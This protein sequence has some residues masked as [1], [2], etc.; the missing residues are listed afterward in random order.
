MIF[1]KVF[2]TAVTV[3]SFFSTVRAELTPDDT[4]CIRWRDSLVVAGVRSLAI[5]DFY[6]ARRYFTAAFQCGMHRDSM[7]YFAAEMY[8]RR[9]ALDTALVFNRALEKSTTF[10]RTLRDEQRSRIYRLL[11]RTD[12]ADS[13]AALV[14]TPLRHDI[15]LN[16]SG[17]RRDMV[18]GPITFLPQQITIT[19]GDEY[20]D[21]GKSVFRYKLSQQNLPLVR[22]LSF[23]ADVQSDIRLPTRYSFNESYDT[24]MYGGGGLLAA[25]DGMAVPYTAAG[26][27]ARIHQ[28]GKTDH[29]T[30]LSLSMAAGKHLVF[31]LGNED[32]WIR[33][34]GLDEARTEAGCTMLFRGRRMQPSF[35]L[36]MAH[37]FSRFDLYQDKVTS[38]RGLYNPLPLGFVDTLKA[39]EGYRYFTDRACTI[40]SVNSDLPARYYQQQPGMRFLAPLPEHDINATLRTSLMTKLPL[41]M[42]MTLFGSIQGVCFTKNV[43]WYATD[44]PYLVYFDELYEDCAIIYNAA[45]GG[46]YLIGDKTQQ[47]YTPA[48]LRP[49]R[50]HEKRRVDCFMALSL[51]LDREFGEYG[52]VYF[53]ISGFKGFSTLRATDPVATFNYGWE[54]SAGWK[55]EVALPE[56]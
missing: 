34:Q 31:T 37:R 51:V 11:G 30:S 17:L 53:T 48:Q 40:P 47:T 45:D 38:G 50:R 8:L 4:G 32:K 9:F 18:I 27:R 46:Y 54:L 44:Q 2:F 36:V 42:G 6:G 14:K 39:D 24:L 20:D 29:Y 12:L 22:R 5:N 26:Y 43:V 7:S 23:T 55:K 25:G 41:D 15:S 35:G 1:K 52:K 21:L 33:H 16:V 10:S 19:P 49:L 56:K 3:L 13:A 28:D